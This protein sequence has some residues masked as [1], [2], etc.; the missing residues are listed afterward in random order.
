MTLQNWA[1]L[2]A[3]A[4][5]ITGPKGGLYY[6]RNGQRVYITLNEYKT[7]R[8]YRAPKRGAY[9]RYLANIKEI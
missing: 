2:P 1:D 6:M 5:L 9:A 4:E 3:D 7:K 8:K